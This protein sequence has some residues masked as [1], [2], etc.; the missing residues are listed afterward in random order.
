MEVNSKAFWEKVKEEYRPNKTG[1]TFICS[2]SSTFEEVWS[3]LKKRKAI[4][5]L[6]K[7]Y[8]SN[9]DSDFYIGF[10]TLFNSEKEMDSTF[11]EIRKDF[12][13]WCIAKFS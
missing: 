8:L 2:Q 5:N 4:K 1:Y 10:E 7:K 12:I 9:I 6:G 11:I 13:D 3:N